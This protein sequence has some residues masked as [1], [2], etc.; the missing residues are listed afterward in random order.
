MVE[1]YPVNQACTTESQEKYTKTFD[2]SI[3]LVCAVNQ[4]SKKINQKSLIVIV[5]PV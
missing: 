3:F 1:M 4:N 2:L 5:G